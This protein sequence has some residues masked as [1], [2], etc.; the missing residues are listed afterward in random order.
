[1]VS[2]IKAYFASDFHLG[3]DTTTQTSEDREKIII[4]WLTN[5]EQ[6]ATHIFLL[7]DFFDYWFEYSDK[8]A[9]TFDRLFEKLKTLKNKGIN[10]EFFTGNH[11]MWMKNY[12]TDNYK[13]PIHHQYIIRELNGKFFFLAHGDGLGKGDFLYKLIK[14]VFLN[15]YCQKLFSLIPPT[16]GLSIM[17]NISK[18]SRENY[19][20]KI[21]KIE[22]DRLV[23]FCEEYISESKVDYFILGHRHLPMHYRISKYKRE[24]Y[25][26]GDWLNHR[27][28]LIF[29]GQKLSYKFYKNDTSILLK[30]Y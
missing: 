6:D 23:Q 30:N 17:K 22:E 24:Y 28:Y 16:I 21:E 20:E 19:H 8:P 13:I 4:D 1:L 18:T 7:G 2:S 5:I 25:N 11:D 26:L 14:R 10:I 3:L 12:F 9:M 29:D 27:S 15:T